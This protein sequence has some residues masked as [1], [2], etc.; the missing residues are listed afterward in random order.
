[1]TGRD[2]TDV[3][4]RLVKLIGSRARSGEDVAAAARGVYDDLAVVL[5]PLVSEAGFEALIVRALQLAQR[6]FPPGEAPGHDEND[7]TPFGEIGRWL[8]RQD[9]RDAIDAAAA[10]FAAVA[11]VLGTLIGDS[12]TTRYLR[13]AW[14]D[15]FPTA[16]A[17]GNDH[18]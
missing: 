15:G 14:P 16:A 2:T 3:R 7:A 5:V 8:S 18:D 9:V 13:K 17:K 4:K 6:E 10:M 12:L 1:M 11:A